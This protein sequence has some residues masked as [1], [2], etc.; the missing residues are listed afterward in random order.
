MIEPDKLDS[1]NRLLE[2]IRETFKA[3]EVCGLRVVQ[4]CLLSDQLY[5]MCDSIPCLWECINVGV[6]LVAYSLRLLTVAVL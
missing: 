1:L 4:P 2:I 3:V 5:V 6:P